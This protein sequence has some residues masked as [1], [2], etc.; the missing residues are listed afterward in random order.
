MGRPSTSSLPGTSGSS[1][2]AEAISLH[3]QPGEREHLLDDDV[4]ELQP[5]D[6]PP[7]YSEIDPGSAD[8][9]PA[10]P[11]VLPPWYIVVDLTD[12]DLYKVDA[13]SGVEFLLCGC[14]DNDPVLLERQIKFSA[15]KPPRPSI[16]IRGSHRQTVQENGKSERKSVTDFDIRVELTPYLF[17]DAPRS[18]S[19]RRLRTV[20]NTE[21]TRRGTIFPTRAPG[22]TRD[23]E[24]SGPKPTLAEWCHRYCA[25]HAGVKAFVLRRQVTGFDQ[26][27]LK[28]RLEALV[29]GTNY[30]GQLDITFP[31]GDDQIVVYN[32]CRINRW[33]LTPWI[34]WFCYLTFLWLLTW[35]FLF[36]RTKRFDVAIAEWPFSVTEANGEKRYV[37]MSEEQIYNLWGRAIRRAVLARHQGTLSEQDLIASQTTPDEPFSEV[38]QH[39]PR[40]LREGVNAISAVN[41]QVGWGGDSW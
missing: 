22:V 15:R 1:S 33:R 40:F 37:S 31:V 30:Q 16:R 28:Q 24:I 8:N 32:A 3:T 6:L 20:E 5:A 11:P 17:S 12:Q 19:W 41:L 21:K 23:I 27:M 25:S 39:A 29:R 34:V 36:F 38:L 18:K 10:I 35:P 14:L 7:P 9:P 4:P 13:N 2:S 26:E